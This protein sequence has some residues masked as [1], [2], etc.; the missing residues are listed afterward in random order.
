MT[1][2]ELD[3][4]FFVQMVWSELEKIGNAVDESGDN[5]DVGMAEDVPEEMVPVQELFGA[6]IQPLDKRRAMGTPVLPPPPG[7]VYVPELQ[8]FAPDPETAGWMTEAQAAIAQN[9]AQYY[10]QGQ[11]DATAGAAQQQLDQ[12]AQQQQQMMAQQQMDHQQSE[13]AQNYE[14]QRQGLANQ[15]QAQRQAV[16]PS[17]PSTAR[18]QA[19]RGAGPQ[20]K[21]TGRR[22]ERGIVIK[23]GR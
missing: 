16:N 3:A 18:P 10:Q 20:Q 12:V 2:S 11:Q 14:L 8:V 9:N 15:R 21:P 13:M 22:G 6:Q 17:R 5:Q 19:D 7:Y 4:R 1:R 23:L